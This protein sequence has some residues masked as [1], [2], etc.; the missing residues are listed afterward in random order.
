VVSSIRPLSY[1]LSRYLVDSPIVPLVRP[2]SRRFALGGFVYPLLWLLHRGGCFRRFSS[3]PRHCCCCCCRCP[4]V[5]VV[6]AAA[7]AGMVII[8]IVATA[9]RRRRRA[10][11][12]LSRSQRNGEGGNGEN[13]PR[14][15]SRFVFGTHCMGLPYHGSPLVLLHPQFLPSNANKPAHI[16]LEREGA[17]VVAPSLLRERGMICWAHIPQWRRGARIRVAACR[18]GRIGDGEGE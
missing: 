3:L 13:E 9:D 2:P 11:V 4:I 12:L 10:T 15:P 16:P 1:R 7:A 5:V 17:A 8:I 14:F 18:L 6:F